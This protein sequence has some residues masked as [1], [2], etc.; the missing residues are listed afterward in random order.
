MHLIMWG[1]EGH[2]HSAVK[3]CCR[4]KACILHENRLVPSWSCSFTPVWFL[5][6]PAPLPRFGSFM[7]LLL[8]YP[9]LVPS[10]SCSF[11]PVWFL[12][13]PAPLPRFG[14]FMIL[15]LYPGLVPSWSCSSTPVWFLHDPA[16]LP[17]FGSFMILLLYP[18]SHWIECWVG[19]ESFWTKWWQKRLLPS[20]ESNSSFQ[21]G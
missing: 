13:D 14:S 5:H 1:W 20:R 4:R 12:H 8:L 21:A 19:P 10:W 11:A 2:R 16:P 7:I 6:D 17:R 18:G 9:G 3:A 15:L